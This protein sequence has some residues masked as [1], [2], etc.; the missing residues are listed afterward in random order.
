VDQ[1]SASKGFAGGDIVFGGRNPLA[2]PLSSTLFEGDRSCDRTLIVHLVELRQ[3]FRD[4]SLYL[5]MM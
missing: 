4:T 2:C 5:E 3:D 1:T